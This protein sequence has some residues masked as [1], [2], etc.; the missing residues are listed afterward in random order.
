M[1]LLFP[2]EWVSYENDTSFFSWKQFL[3]KQVVEC[4][5]QQHLQA[6]W[7][8]VLVNVLAEPHACHSGAPGEVGQSQRRHTG[9]ARQEL[10]TIAPCPLKS[11]CPARQRE[12]REPSMSCIHHQK[13][14]FLH[15]FKSRLWKSYLYKIQ[16]YFKKS[17]YFPADTTLVWDKEKYLLREI[18]PGPLFIKGNQ[19]L[20][21]RNAK[22][23]LNYMV[24]SWYFS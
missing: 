17:F 9:C 5:P 14:Y 7:T 16:N 3:W 22:L 20:K 12:G 23:L 18:S 13:L 24:V 2:S 1:V 19:Q 15:Y 21:Y 10:V 6:R 8:I 11:L 4:Q